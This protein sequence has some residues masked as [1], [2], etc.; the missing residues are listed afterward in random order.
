[1]VDSLVVYHRWRYFHSLL[2]VVHA[3]YFL[4]KMAHVVLGEISLQGAFGF[5]ER[6]F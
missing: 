4:Q 2:S 3:A 5:C 1:M 6:V